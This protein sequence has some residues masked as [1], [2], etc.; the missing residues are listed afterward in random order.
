MGS[1]QVGRGWEGD[2]GAEG[3]KGTDRQRA[4]GGTAGKACEGE[5]RPVGGKGKAAQ[6]SGPGKT[7]RS[8][9]RTRY[10]KTKKRRANLRPV[11]RSSLTILIRLTSPTIDDTPAH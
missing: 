7:G 10:E 3:G 4:G 8:G 2:R 6:G 11:E 9:E 1:G 5:C